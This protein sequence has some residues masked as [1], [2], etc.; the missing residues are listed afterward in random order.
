MIRETNMTMTHFKL[1]F[2]SPFLDINTLIPVVTQF[3]LFDKTTLSW[4]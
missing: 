2:Y 4:F 3:S 1:K